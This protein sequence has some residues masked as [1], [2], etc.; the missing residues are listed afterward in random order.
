MFLK[1]VA[2][3]NDSSV[4]TSGRIDELDIVAFSGGGSI[5]LMMRLCNETN[6]FWLVNMG[7]TFLLPYDSDCV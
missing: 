3:C 7:K 6:D 5:L 4:S 2:D 1:K